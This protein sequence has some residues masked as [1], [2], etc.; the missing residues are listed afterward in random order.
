MQYGASYPTICWPLNTIRN[1]VLCTGPLVYL[2]IGDYVM[3]L[4]LGGERMRTEWRFTFQ[5][6]EIK[7]HSVFWDVTLCSL[8]ETCRRFG[9]ICCLHHQFR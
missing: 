8:A 2:N 7:N 9:V 4:G 5:T 3:F 1:F 6:V